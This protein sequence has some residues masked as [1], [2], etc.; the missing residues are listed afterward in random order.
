MQL[1]ININRYKTNKKKEQFQHPIKLKSKSFK[2]KTC[3][4]VVAKLRN[5]VIILHLYKFKLLHN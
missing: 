5:K 2:M 4:S 1:K 3:I